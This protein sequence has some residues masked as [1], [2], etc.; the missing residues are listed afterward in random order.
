MTT[1]FLTD[2]KKMSGSEKLSHGGSG[3][4]G[5]SIRERVGKGGGGY[6]SGA[7]AARGSRGRVRKVGVVDGSGGNAIKETCC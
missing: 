5:R 6:W 4:S 2:D 1:I 7:G 3:G